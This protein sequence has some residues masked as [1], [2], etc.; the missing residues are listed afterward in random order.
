MFEHRT[1][2]LLPF[3]AFVHRVSFYSGIAL[4]IVVVALGIGILGY[5]L[6]EHFDWIDS[7]LNAAMILGGMGPVN[8]VV[9]V[10]GKIFA[11]CYALFSG[12]IFL[13][14]VGV[15]FAPLIHRLLHKIHL[16]LGDQDDE[17]PTD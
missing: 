17:R 4:V 1:Q 12:V 15:I 16:D 13:I 10:A 7:F 8:P 9:T 6:T 5:H 3:R 14:A 11:G 2:P